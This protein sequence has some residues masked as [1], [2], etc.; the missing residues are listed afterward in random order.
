M[1][2]PGGPESLVQ[3]LDTLRNTSSLAIPGLS[4]NKED[5]TRPQKE[6]KVGIFFHHFFLFLYFSSDLIFC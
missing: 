4:A 3:L 2:R 6:K 5:K 1:G